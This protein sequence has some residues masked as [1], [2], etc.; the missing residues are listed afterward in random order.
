MTRERFEAE[1]SYLISL[2]MAKA[3]LNRKIITPPELTKIKKSLASRYKPTLSP[4]IE[5]ERLDNS[6]ETG[7]HS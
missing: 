5:N 2:N 7:I 1:K 3:L 6:S 4:F